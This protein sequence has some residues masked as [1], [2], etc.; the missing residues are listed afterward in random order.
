[1]PN[2]ECDA[3]NRF[4]IVIGSTW[5]TARAYAPPGSQPFAREQLSSLAAA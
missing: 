5:P 3:H 4:S 2:H 1:M